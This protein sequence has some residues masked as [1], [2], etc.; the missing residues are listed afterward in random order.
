MTLHVVIKNT[1]ERDA[2]ITLLNAHSILFSEFEY[3]PKI[4]TIDWSDIASFPLKDSPHIQS[5]EEESNIRG[6]DQALNIAGN[7]SNASWGLARIIRRSPPWHIDRLDFPTDTFF[8]CLRTGIG[9]DFYVLDSGVRTTHAEFGG[10]VT[11]VYEYYNS[12]GLGD[13]YGH[14]TA[15]SGCAAGATTGL[16]RAS[17]IFSFKCLNSSNTGTSSGILITINHVLSHYNGRSATNRPAVVNISIYTAS[18]G[19]DSA[20][21][22]MID[23]GMIVISIAGNEYRDLGTINQYPAESDA[24]V[25]VVGGI[26]PADIPYYTGGYG[27][28]YGTRVDVSAPAQNL[29]V[30]FR[31]SDSTYINWNGTSFAAPLVAGIACCLLS[32]RPRLT[33][34]AQVQAIR[35]H[36]RNTATTG[37]LVN[38]AGWPSNLPDRIAYIDPD[39]SDEYIAGID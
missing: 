23:A 28:S 37:H 38:P 39:V 20:V 4:F 8:R 9:V 15:V 14:G 22:A 2:W 16:A 25:I 35:N 12:G 10:R 17:D 11:T 21:T 26:G 18:S 5:I 30:P 1:D 27:T 24:D 32:N 34:R 13:D 19:F 29:W 31:T 7:F 6:S 3:L 36:I 33:G